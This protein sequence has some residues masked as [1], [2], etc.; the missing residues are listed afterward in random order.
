MARTLTRGTG[1]LTLARPLGGRPLVDVAGDV[2]VA[3]TLERL[4]ASGLD[5]LTHARLFSVVGAHVAGARVAA[6]QLALSARLTVAAALPHGLGRLNETFD[7]SVGVQGLE[8]SLAA[9]LALEAPRVHALQVR[10][11]GAPPSAPP[12]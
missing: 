8:A 1:A 7:V 9:L 2:R 6:A 3:L 5:S 4:R 11:A 12:L 10:R